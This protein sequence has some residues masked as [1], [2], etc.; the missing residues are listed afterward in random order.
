M[1]RSI[2]MITS[3]LIF[4]VTYGYLCLINHAY[5]SVNG[6]FLWWNVRWFGDAYGMVNDGLCEMGNEFEWLLDG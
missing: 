1:I 5:D 4:M 3:I 6:G 2:L